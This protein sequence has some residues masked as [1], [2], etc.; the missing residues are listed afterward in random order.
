MRGKALADQPIHQIR[1]NLV[2]FILVDKKNSLIWREFILVG[3]YFGGRPNNEFVWGEVGRSFSN[4]ITTE[5]NKT[6]NNF[7]QLT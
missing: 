6:T 3:I 1:R 7:S 5:R 2:E 4:G